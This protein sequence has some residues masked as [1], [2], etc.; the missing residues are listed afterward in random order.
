[1]FSPALNASGGGIVLINGA[2]S[3]PTKAERAFYDKTGG[4]IGKWLDEL[5]VA[6]SV[7][8]ESDLASGRARRATIIIL[9]YNP[10]LS[11][12]QLERLETFLANGGKLIVCYGS[13]PRLAEL[14]GVQLGKYQAAKEPGR[15]SS[16]RFN[17]SAPPLTPQEVIQ[18]SGN[19]FPVR[20]ISGTSKIIACWQDAGGNILPDPAWLQ[21]DKGFWMTHI[22]LG[23]DS[24]NKKKML[25]AMLAFY[26]PGL[27]KNAA[28]RELRK[29]E[30]FAGCSGVSDFISALKSG[31]SSSG[32]ELS[33]QIDRINSQYALLRNYF[34]QK[35][36]RQAVATAY[37]LKSLLINA[38]AMSQAR[39]SG[40]EFRGVWN[41]SG[42]GLFPGNWDKTCRV[43]A[44]SGITAVFPNV[45]WAGMAHYPSKYA[46]QS[47]DSKQLGDQLAQCV[48]AAHR[49]GLEVH[50]WKVCWNLEWADKGFIEKM[51]RQGRL[52][53]NNR[54]ETVNW[55]CPSDPANVAFELN[56][57]RE[58]A[59]R[60]D[61]DGIHLDYIRY[62]DVN[63]CFC[64][65]CR[66]RY[67]A[68]SGRTVKNWPRDVLSGKLADTYS[69]WRSRQITEFMR[70]VRNETKKINMK[71]KLSAAVYP[72]YPECSRSIGQDWG[73]WLREGLV[74][75]VCP[76]DYFPDVSA[77]NEM[78]AHRNALRK[79]GKNIYPG[80]GAT[81]TNGD[82]DGGVFLGQLSALRRYG[83][84]G[85]MLFDLN[86]SL[87]KNFLPLLG[88]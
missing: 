6:Y 31:A 11:G 22:L 30:R 33:T 57:I 51:R 58:A 62:P 46:A 49:A 54:G 12:K 42:L 32:A 77:F 25:L 20:P 27:W 88:K 40:K 74:D 66:Q 53:K 48:S 1:L 60:Y 34:G 35:D 24:E 45:L 76:M 21:S 41:H 28:Q 65:G 61:L 85:F 37:K 71:I 80:I 15:W 3:A 26:D 38:Y 5:G 82:L 13:N 9:P 56:A 78:L 55:L 16:F 50:A 72:K 19:I 44:Q 17:G 83:A 52:Q 70:A 67:E 18:D 36:Y 84:G 64:P 14:F 7:R 86:R 69:T 10:N 63:T 79:Y 87:S 29:I 47:D 23:E 75:F 73:V 4:R 81:L 68:W 39:L 2:S 59:S 43:L 8:T